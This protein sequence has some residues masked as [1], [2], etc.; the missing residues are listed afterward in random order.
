MKYFDIEVTIREHYGDRPLMVFVP[1][2]QKYCPVHVCPYNNTANGG[3]C[4][5]CLRIVMPKEHVCPFD[6]DCP[7]YQQLKKDGLI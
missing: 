6:K 1:N 5:R 7:V 2:T 3:D 4:G